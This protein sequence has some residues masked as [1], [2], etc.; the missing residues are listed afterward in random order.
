[1]SADR[2]TKILRHAMLVLALGSSSGCAFA[3]SAVTE[4][5]SIELLGVKFKSG[6]PRINEEFNLS[7]FEDVGNQ[8][9]V[10]RSDLQ[11]FRDI[12]N[13]RA[14]IV[15]HTDNLECQGGECEALS[16]RRAEGIYEWLVANGIPNESLEGP[17][18]EGSAMPLVRN[19]SEGNRAQ[20]RRV[21]INIII[22][23]N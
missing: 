15:G 3:E 17:R 14:E 13:L 23:V 16:L 2:A 20:N 21:E 8:M 4:A 1:M 5:A 18:G 22:P 6:R 7:Q 11:A 12:P 10:L 9:Q 19:T